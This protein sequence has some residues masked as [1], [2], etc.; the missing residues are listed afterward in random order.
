MEGSCQP[1]F[2]LI[3]SSGQDSIQPVIIKEEGFECLADRMSSD[4][5]QYRDEFWQDE[6]DPDYQVGFIDMFYIN[7]LI[8]FFTLQLYYFIACAF[9]NNFYICF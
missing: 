7:L 2:V 5:G 4:S 9:K 6:D 3:L 1:K 8:S